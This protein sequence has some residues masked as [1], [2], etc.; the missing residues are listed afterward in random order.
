MVLNTNERHNP[1]HP[2]LI[3][4]DQ[5]V[6]MA[7]L[8]TALERAG[9]DHLLCC[10]DERTVMSTLESREVEIIL[11]DLVM[12]H[13]SG[14]ILLAQIRD[15]YPQIPVIVTTGTNDI[16]TVV[17]CMQKGAHDYITKPIDEA[18]LGA[19]AQRAIHLRELQRQNQR[20]SQHLLAESPEHGEHFSEIMTCDRKM[21]A[22]FRYCE[23]IAPG[24][25]PV[26][27]T[28]ETGTGKEL[29]ARA[30]HAAS[31]RKGEFVAVNVAG[32]DDHVFSDTLF[33]HEK[34]AF[35][36]ADRPRRG[37][38]H[39][40][41]G[42]TLFLDEIGELS[43]PSQIKLL[44]VI[45]ERE[46]F[47]LG[48][49]RPIKTDARI[50]VATHKNMETLLAKGS[51]RQDL[52]FRLRT[53]HMEMPPLR[54]RADDIPLL[55]E[56]FFEQAAKEFGKRKPTYPPELIQLLKVHPFRG[57]VREL[58]AM[59]YDA[60]ARHTSKTLSTEAFKKYIFPSSSPP[61]APANGAPQNIYTGLK[62]LP[63]IKTAVEALI[64]AAL[65]QSGSN[66][67]I[68]AAMLGITPPALS[69]RLKQRA[70]GAERP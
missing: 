23:A 17:R 32:V 62:P 58:R 21:R 6:A 61:A 64:D 29:M 12:P 36:G 28:G 31:G 63:T 9:Y 65:E 19:A 69:K 53:H 44:R 33:G 46:F 5:K 7:F 14:E 1:V 37:F 56:C 50:I 54:D 27:I 45:Q 13:I 20:L 42:G 41:A 34:G 15:R 68:A 67:K 25:E 16:A 4:D 35:T 66:Q 57:N 59:V 10:L 8:S 47:A 43:E 30:F 52:Y 11:L 60:V 38:I 22:L 3:V 51:F 39:K 49:D 26:L 2:I 70:E 18:L 48:S 55:L 40:A 24:R